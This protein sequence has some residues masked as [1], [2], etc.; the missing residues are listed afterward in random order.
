MGLE[1]NSNRN[2]LSYENAV[3]DNVATHA[4]SHKWL[5]LSHSAPVR[6]TPEVGIQIFILYYKFRLNIFTRDFFMSFGAVT[7]KMSILSVSVN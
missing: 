1:E 4:T 3:M 2:G 5:N 6:E 7:Q